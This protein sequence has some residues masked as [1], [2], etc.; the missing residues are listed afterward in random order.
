MLEGAR[1]EL[2]IDMRHKRMR[3][4]MR[5]Q[6]SSITITNVT[7]SYVSAGTETNNTTH[8]T[9]SSF[10]H[11]LGTG[12]VL[13]ERH[14]ILFQQRH[15]E[16]RCTGKATQDPHSIMA[17]R[18][19]RYV[20]MPQDSLA[21]LAQRP[22]IYTALHL[23]TDTCACAPSNTQSGPKNNDRKNMLGY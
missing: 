1:L 6:S 3:T 9:R 5:P 11:V 23:E 16:Q 2:R 4:Y 12:D 14:D 18:P 17:Q 20:R 21:A 19:E 13:E 8:I 15:K 22:A 10:H 7:Q